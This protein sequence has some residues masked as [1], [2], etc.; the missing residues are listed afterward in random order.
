MRHV[1]VIVLSLTL[2]A[3][4]TCNEYMLSK[5]FLKERAAAVGPYGSPRTI[6]GAKATWL[7]AQLASNAYDDP[8]ESFQL[9]PE[10]R[11]VKSVNGRYGF[12]ATVYERATSDGSVAEVIIAIR[13]TERKFSDWFHGN[14]LGYQYPESRRVVKEI[15]SNPRYTTAQISATGHSLGGGISMYLS[16][17]EEGVA[18]YAFN[19]SYRVFSCGDEIRNHRVAVMEEGDILEV[20]RPF[21]RP[22]PNVTTYDGFY[23][24]Y[25]NN[26][27]MYRL[28][29][30][31]THVATMASPDAEQSLK[32]NLV[33]RCVSGR[34]HG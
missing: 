18:A 4:A 9:P 13:G 12:E 6:V 27:A 8:S 26:H 3:C 20:F 25:V 15:R 23:C 30:C 31:L 16:T 17:C 11:K 14:L 22:P 19:P 29:R 7:Y 1:L 28:A 10:M 21:Q 34:D 24:S 33:P 32:V 2:T 5:P